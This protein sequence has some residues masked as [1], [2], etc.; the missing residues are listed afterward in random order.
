MGTY[1]APNAGKFGNA[2]VAFLN[3]VFKGDMKAKAMF[4]D[5]DSQLVK[6]NWNI[7]MRNW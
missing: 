1:F 3:W 7:S 6:D 2:S 4:F 5:K